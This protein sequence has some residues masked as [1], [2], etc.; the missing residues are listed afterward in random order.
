MNY[1]KHRQFTL[2]MILKEC[3]KARKANGGTL[4]L[5]PSI[6]EVVKSES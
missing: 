2:A 5:P 3:Y 4:I 1:F 6:T